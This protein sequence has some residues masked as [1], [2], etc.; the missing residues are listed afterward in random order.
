MMTSMAPL[1]YQKQL[2]LFEA[3][4]L[5]ISEQA[6]VEV[7]A[8]EVGF[9]SVSQFSREYVRTF[10]SPPRREVSAWKTP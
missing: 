3:R 6:T 10:G 2:R 5:M 4:R 1:Q 9:A 7:A 8:F